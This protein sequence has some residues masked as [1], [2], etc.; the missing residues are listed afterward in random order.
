MRPAQESGTKPTINI[1]IFKLAF[2]KQ[3]KVGR[4]WQF[5]CQVMQHAQEPGKKSIIIKIFKLAFRIQNEG[6][7]G[8]AARL[9]GYATRSGTWQTNNH[10][11]Y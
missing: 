9:T 6:G 11:Y 7:P 8:V 5:G 10:H 1:K 3:K 4:V 2:R